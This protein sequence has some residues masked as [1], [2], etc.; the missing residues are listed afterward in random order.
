M[1]SAVYR[2]D[3]PLLANGLDM[4]ETTVID[5]TEPPPVPER[6]KRRPFRFLFKLLVVLLIVVLA[7]LYW[8]LAQIPHVEPDPD[9]AVGLVDQTFLLSGSDSRADLPD[10][11]AGSFGDFGGERSDVVILAHPTGGTLQLLSLPRDLKVSI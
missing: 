1:P 9:L 4:D 2:L 6:P 11:L 3:L 8:G 5:L 7:G 10:D